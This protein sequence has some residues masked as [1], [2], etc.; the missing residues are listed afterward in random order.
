MFH[1]P[2]QQRASDPTDH[3][4]PDQ[5][6]V[7]SLKR[8]PRQSVSQS[9]SLRS[10]PANTAA[11]LPCCF[12][13]RTLQLC[14]ALSQLPSLLLHGRVWAMTHELFLFFVGFLGSHGS[15][16]EAFVDERLP[17]HRLSPLSG[18]TRQPIFPC[19]TLAWVKRQTVNGRHGVRSVALI[20]EQVVGAH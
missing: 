18:V 17:T 20:F 4:D 9:V 19:R 14:A 5:E 3:L 7:Y 10:T 16:P 11:W 8:R 6:V 2:S 13:L 1:F 12:C 15:T